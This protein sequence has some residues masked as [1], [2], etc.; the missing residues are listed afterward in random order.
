LTDKAA[1]E[2]FESLVRGAMREAGIETLAELARRSGEAAESW[3]GWFAG[4]HRP[5]AKSLRQAADILGLT[6]EDMHA[7]WDDGPP[8]PSRPAS[9]QSALVVALSRQVE[10]INALVEALTR[11]PSGLRPEHVAWVEAQV[12]RQS[13]RTAPRPGRKPGS[14]PSPVDPPNRQRHGSA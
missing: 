9:D 13:Q 1:G 5:R 4:R 8:R 2:R 6:V 3:H 11:P 10:A 7:A 14:S 12:R